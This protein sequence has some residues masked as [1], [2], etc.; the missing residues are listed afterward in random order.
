MNEAQTGKASVAPDA[1][2][3]IEVLRL[4]PRH[5]QPEVRELFRAGQPLVIARAPGRLDVMGGIADYSGSLVLQR[6]I[7]EATF[8]ALQ[9]TEERVVKVVSLSAEPGGRAKHYELALDAF[10][11]DGGPVGYDEARQ[12]FSRDAESHWAAYVVG[13]FVVLMRERGVR[14]GQ[15]ARILIASRVPEGKGVSS[16]AALEV[17]TMRA[18][19]EAFGIDLAP[20]ETALLC[21]RVENLV[22]GAPCGVMDQMTSACG[23]A[24]ALLAL[25]C[26]PAELQPPV[27][28]P[29]GLA[30]W[31]LDSGERHAVSGAN[32]GSVRTGAFMGYRIIAEIA[33]LKVEADEEAG[34]VVIDDDRWQGYLANLS[35]SEFERE[36]LPHLP[37]QMSG[38]QFLARYGGT[39]DRA[40]RVDPA[41]L[42]KIQRPA[43]HPIY[44]HHRV[45]SF[46]QMLLALPSEERRM[47]LG[48][49]MFQSH[50]SYAAC[51]LG[52]RGTDLIVSMVRAAGAS[53]GLY[54]ARITGGGSG[55][56]VAI[57]GRRDAE[58]AVAEIVEGYGRITGHRPYVFSGSSDG[59]AKFAP[60]SL[61]L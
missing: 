15:G 8:A 27:P 30:F 19:A 17:A 37:A 58:G 6:T 13:V 9:L 23:E 28:I 45:K 56:T 10:A 46:R 53:K 55:G 25:L 3:F 43:A 61:T 18:V 22:V 33:G 32:Y 1:A 2:A 34:R 42:Y 50:E 26:Q 49:L 11:P 44:E 60:V 36:F 4:L 35:P 48:E 54:G 16:S 39:T 7:A 41:R 14:F 38:T 52:S 47:L 29:E 20:H 57:F 59:A 24:D 5:T 31:G 21:Q 51:G 40:T 12:L